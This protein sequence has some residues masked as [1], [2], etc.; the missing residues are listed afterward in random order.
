MNRVKRA[1]IMAAGKGERMRPVTLKTPKP[2]VRVNGVRMIDTVIRA[3]HENGI[4]E[5]YIVVGY[6]AEQFMQLEIEY[7]GVKILQN[8]YYETS[9]NIASLFVAR[10]HLHDVVILDGDILIYDSK[11]LTPEFSRS[12]Y[13]AIYT[14]EKTKEWLLQVTD[15]V[16]TQCSRTGGKDGWILFSISRWNKEDGAKLKRHLEE[17]FIHCN[18]RQLFWD[19]V[20]LFCYPQE[21]CLGIYPMDRECVIEIDTIEE[22]AIVDKSYLKYV[23][24]E[25]IDG[26]ES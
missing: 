22:L 18:N 8:P 7:P 23:D 21:Y 14:K 3:L 24:K 16:V 13:N 11:V 26:T 12:G 6:L 19:D 5:I 17:Q 15:N 10:E 2:L 4:T 20:A 9:N 25:S 1:I